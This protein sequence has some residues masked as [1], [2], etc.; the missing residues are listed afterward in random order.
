MTQ[1]YRITHEEELRRV[2]ER[3]RLEARLEAQLKNCLEVLL[4]YGIVPATVLELGLDLLVMETQPAL[5]LLIHTRG[6]LDR[7]RAHI[8]PRPPDSVT[9]ADRQYIE[10]LLQECHSY[11][12]TD[13]PGPD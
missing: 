13:Y 5:G 6:D 10:D 8:P 7:L 12:H 9:A 4:A 11:P 2:A 3:T 1:P